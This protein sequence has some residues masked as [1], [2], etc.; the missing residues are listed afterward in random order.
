MTHKSELHNLTTKPLQNSQSISRNLETL[1]KC[2]VA[3]WQE[4]FHIYQT[5]NQF[6]KCVC[7]YLAWIPWNFKLFFSALGRSGLKHLPLKEGPRNREGPNSGLAD[8]LPRSRCSSHRES[9]GPL[10]GFLP[11]S[12]QK[13][14]KTA[15]IN[16]FFTFLV[17]ELVTLNL[18][19]SKCYF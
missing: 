10:S 1:R 18:R 5:I 6:E 4:N 7:N 17:A 11:K 2:T 9:K 14:L 16:G 19:Q 12:Y 13:I 8:N 15:K 3:I